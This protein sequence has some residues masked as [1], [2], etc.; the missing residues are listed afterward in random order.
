LIDV[1]FA[2]P[3]DVLELRAD[4]RYGE[5]V[6]AIWGQLRDEVQQARATTGM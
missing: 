1:P 4:P 6:L 5:L 2:R 3:R